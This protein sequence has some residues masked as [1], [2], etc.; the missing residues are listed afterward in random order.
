[1]TRTLTLPDAEHEQFPTPPLKVM[2]G[3]VRFP[4]ILKIAEPAGLAPFQEEIRE[5]YSE[6]SEEQQLS[7]AV[8]PEGMSAAGESRNYRFTTTD[9]AWSVVLNPMF[10]TLEASIAKKY[11]NYQ[12]FRDRFAHLWDVALRHLR[13]TKSVQQGLRYIDFFDWDDVAP[14]EWGRYINAHLLGVLGAENIV[15]HV[16][17]TL[18]DTRLQL[19]SEMGLSLKYGLVRSGPEN[20]V[21]FLM[22]TDCLSQAPQEDV[23]V[24]AILSRF[25]SFHD[26]IHVLFHWAVTP[27]AKERFRGGSASSH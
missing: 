15:E 8:G 3:Q 10:L 14:A 22:D 20:A 27:E 23:S 11:S 13:P 6:Y 17:H 18:T 16:Q 5:E 26:E 19:T 7:L 9:G 2:L 1:M 24:E 25:D 12:E 21:G 4:A